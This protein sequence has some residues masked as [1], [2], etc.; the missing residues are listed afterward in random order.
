MSRSKKTPMSKIKGTSDEAIGR[1]K[2]WREGRYQKAGEPVD[3]TVNTESQPDHEPPKAD[4]APVT[5]KDYE[6][7]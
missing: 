5:K 4:E 6:E 1:P 3:Q 2:Q 7:L